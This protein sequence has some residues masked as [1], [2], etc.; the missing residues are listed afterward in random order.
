ME[1]TA[2]GVG[3][4]AALVLALSFLLAGVR[5]VQMPAATREAFRALRVPGADVAARLVPLIELAL[6]VALAVVPRVGAVLS[7][8]TLAVFTTFLGDR[9]RRGVTAP[10]AC[11]GTRSTRPLSQREMVR[12]LGFAVLALLALLAPRPVVPTALDVI[13]VAAVVA[14][15]AVGHRL[16]LRA[17]APEGAPA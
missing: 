13:V 11:F 1:I 9:L 10:C 12:N 14:A 7:L 8:V 4:V 15:G 16:A 5:K 2:A 3:T 6:G 17:L